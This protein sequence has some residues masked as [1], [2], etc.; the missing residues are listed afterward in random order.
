MRCAALES[1]LVNR[2]SQPVSA[3]KLVMSAARLNMLTDDVN[4]LEE[5]LQKM[6]LV[7]GSCTGS[8]VDGINHLDSQSNGVCCGNAQ[9]GALIQADRANGIHAGP[10]ITDRFS[11]E[12]LPQLFPTGRF[13]TSTPGKPLTLY[14]NPS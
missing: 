4:V 12:G 14:R 8:V 5:A 1:R 2:Q 3:D 6:P 7:D 13:E 9:R 11:Q 10:D